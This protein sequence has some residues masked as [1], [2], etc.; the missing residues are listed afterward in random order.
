[1]KLPLA[2][3]CRNVSVGVVGGGVPSSAQQA[4]RPDEVRPQPKL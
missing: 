1:M 4:S 2:S 3:I